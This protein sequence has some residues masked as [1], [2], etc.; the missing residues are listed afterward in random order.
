MDGLS[1][2]VR[3]YLYINVHLNSYTYS[4]VTALSV[5]FRRA[6]S[7]P[8]IHDPDTRVARG[9]HMWFACVVV[10]TMKFEKF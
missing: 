7:V 10:R 6:S 5:R 3:V 4:L 8:E 2:R 1:R 9:T